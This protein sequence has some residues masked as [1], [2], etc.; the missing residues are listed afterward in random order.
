MHALC[1]RAAEIAS[2][3]DSGPA[4][5]APT[6]PAPQAIGETMDLVN[7]STGR[8]AHAGRRDLIGRS[9]MDDATGPNVPELSRQKS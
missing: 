4:F 3:R 1:P 9:Y 5:E 8:H 7:R 2:V 6:T